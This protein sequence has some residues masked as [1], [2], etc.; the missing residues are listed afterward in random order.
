MGC[1]GIVERFLAAMVAH[2]WDA[3]SACLADDGFSRVGPFGDE[4]ASKAAY[5]EFIGALIPTLPGYSMDLHRVSY[6][7]RV[8]YAE[9]SETVTV[10][11]APLCTAECLVFELASDGCIERV[12][13]FIRSVAGAAEG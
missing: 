2:D 10:D 4:Y 1:A 11:G 8:A 12:E 13:V 6:A 7:D 3:L 9:L 5:L